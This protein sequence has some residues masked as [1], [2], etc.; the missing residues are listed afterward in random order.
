MTNAPKI[1]NSEKL[2]ILEQIAI[3]NIDVKKTAYDFVFRD[4]K[5][6][7]KSKIKF[8]SI[9]RIKLISNLTENLKL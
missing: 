8:Y 9:P 3:I 2:L 6:E 1:T 5:K 7:G 4:A